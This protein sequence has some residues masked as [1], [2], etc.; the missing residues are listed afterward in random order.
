MDN[1]KALKIPIKE[2]ILGSP[3]TSKLADHIASAIS[4][5]DQTLKD[6]LASVIE[7]HNYGDNKQRLRDEFGGMNIQ[8]IQSNRKDGVKLY[9][10]CENI[11]EDALFDCQNLTPAQFQQFSS[12]VRDLLVP[13][14][15]KGKNKS[16]GLSESRQSEETSK[17]IKYFVA[18]SGLLE[19]RK[20]EV[21]S[22]V[23]GGH[24]LPT[25][26][27][28]EFDEYRF[29]EKIG[30]FNTLINTRKSKNQKQNRPAEDITG[31]GPGIMKAPF[32]GSLQA[33]HELQQKLN[34]FFIGFTESAIMSA[35][36]PNKLIDRLIIFPDIEKRMEAFIRAAHRGRVHPGGIGTLEEIMMFFSIKVHEKNRDSVYPLDFVERPG[37]KYFSYLDN[38][39]KT[40]F[41]DELTESYQLF[42]H[43]LPRDYAIYVRETNKL[44]DRSRLWN[45]D[46]YVPASLQK[47]LKPDFKFVESIEL[48]RDLGSA[49]LLE[50]LRAFFSALVTFNIKQPEIL[51]PWKEERPLL[52]GD[53]KIVNATDQLIQWM[54]S[55]G[56]MKIE[57]EFVKP[58]RT[59]MD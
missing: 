20:R 37:G 11:P 33:F 21:V 12:I 31:S 36:K 18:R 1:F 28:G 38:Y 14:G 59:H 30:Y 24:S 50:N 49:K 22:F 40:C 35:E 48:R 27:I 10:L 52:H 44:I 15:K 47:P 54:A 13:L 5:G 42:N 17:W 3:L 29:A 45:D 19:R 56:R 55:Q 41:K 53:K 25:D 58:Y 51:E 43:I 9:L 4:N 26:Y 6:C 57:G 16:A 2:K 39:L 46:L 8:A 7:T 32:K 23:W 34:R